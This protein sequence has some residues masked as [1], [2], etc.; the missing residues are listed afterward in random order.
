M[1]LSES[2]TSPKNKMSAKKRYS[3]IS[4]SAISLWNFFL[5]LQHAD[6][7]TRFI[8]CL[9]SMLLQFH[10]RQNFIYRASEKF[11]FIYYIAHL[12]YKQVL[13]YVRVMFLKNVAQI[14][15]KIYI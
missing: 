3:Q 8:I 6:I 12:K 10:I 11:L 4:L 5:L 7:N 1:Y 14:K 2:K 13:F 15:H 9:K